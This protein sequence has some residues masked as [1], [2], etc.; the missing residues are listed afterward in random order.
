[1]AVAMQPDGTIVSGQFLASSGEITLNGG[2]TLERS[3]WITFQPGNTTY[4]KVFYNGKE[5]ASTMPVRYAYRVTVVE[6]GIDGKAESKSITVLAPDMERAKL[7]AQYILSANP[8]ATVL[9]VELLG[10]MPEYRRD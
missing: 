7:Y 9:F 6:N 1:M 10:P 3:P 2:V 8:L 4:V 5:I